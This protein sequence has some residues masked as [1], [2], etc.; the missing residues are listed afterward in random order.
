[1]YRGWPSTILFEILATFCMGRALHQQFYHEAPSTWSTHRP[2]P[3]SFLF[4][5]LIVQIYPLSG[6][7]VHDHDARS[8]IHEAYPG[9]LLS[10]SYILGLS[11][12][13]LIEALLGIGR[14]NQHF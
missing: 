7:D 12:L 2:S 10:E 9:L 5:P 4:F 8:V 1:M 11:S 13:A 14:H 3:S 6:A